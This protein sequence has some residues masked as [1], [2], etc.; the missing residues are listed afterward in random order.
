MGQRPRGP[1]P[2]WRPGSDFGRALLAD[3]LERLAQHQREDTLPRSPRGLFYDLRP[4][5]MGHGVTYVKQPAMMVTEGGKRRKVNPMEASP[6]DVQ[7]ILVMARREGMVSENWIEDTRA[8]SPAVPFF[9]DWQHDADDIADQLADMIRNPSLTYSPQANQETHLEVLVEAAGLI[10][11]L[12]RIAAPYGVPV[13]SGGGFG[14][15]KGKRATASRAAGRD[16]PTVVLTI[17]DYDEHGLRIARSA[18]EDSI[19]WAELYYDAE[20]GWLTFE[21]I[22]LTEDQAADHDLLDDAGKAEAEG[23]PVPVM[24]QILRDAIESYQDPDVR[25]ANVERADAERERVTGL[26]LERLSGA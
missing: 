19:A 25:R 6:T 24:D 20:P 16:V 15:L 12:E 22:A 2:G 9:D 8:P 26:V 4:S 23:L 1:Q 13:Y 3:I 14:G 5:G 7:E 18:E 11:R 21:R 17:S 10:G